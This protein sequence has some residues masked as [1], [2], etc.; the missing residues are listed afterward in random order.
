MQEEDEL[1]PKIGREFENLDEAWEFWTEYGKRIGFGVRKGTSTK[2]RADKSIIITYRFL[3]CKEGLR[4]KNEK[5]A[6]ASTHRPETRTNCKA[7]MVVS[8][9]GQKF[10]ITVIDREHNH[11]LHT[12]DTVSLLPCQRNI[13]EA[14]AYEMDLAEESGLEP[15]DTF[16]L[17]STYAGGPENLGYTMTDVKTYLMCKRKRHMKFGEVGCLLEYFQKQIEE[18]PA[19]YHKYQLD[20]DQHITNVFWADAR[21]LI[22][23]AH[24]GE[25]VSLDTTYSTNQ[26]HRP[27]ALFSGFNH[28][29]SVVIFGAALLYDETIESFKWLLETFLDAHIQKK[30]QTVFTDQDQAMARAL[31]EV[32]PNT[33]HCLCSWHLLKN[34]VKHLGNLMKDGSHFLTDFKKCMF[35]YVDVEKFEEAW[36]Q[37]LSSYNVHENGWLKSTYDIKEKWAWCYVKETC[38]LGM[39]STQISESVNADVKRCTKPKLDI[40][41]FFKRFDKVVAKKRYKE[42]ELEYESRQKIPRMV[43]QSAPILRQLVQ[44]YTPTVFDMFQEQWDLQFSVELI[45]RDEKESLFVYIAHMIDQEGEWRVEFKPDTHEI[46]CT[47]Q[48]FESTGIFCCHALK[49]YESKD[50]RV[51]PD[52]YILKR[53]TKEARFG[54]VHDV[55]GNE[56]QVDPRLDITQRYRQL[57]LMMGRLAS[58]AA[59]TLEGFTCVQ[60]CVIELENHI[61]N[62]NENDTSKLVIESQNMPKGFKKRDGKSSKRRWKGWEEKNLKTRRRVVSKAQSN[63]IPSLEA[64]DLMENYSQDFF[65]T[66]SATSILQPV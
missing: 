64:I 43:N 26:N 10:R 36:S 35:N 16:D 3:C 21:M 45:T 63:E 49:V 58:K 27:L 53:W 17:M 13:S 9:V 6:Y 12:K 50:V 47:C 34:G 51:M 59:K 20:P 39:R 55:R 14:Q 32:L 25:V 40:K 41:R 8:R 61:P 62:G 48:K 66:L 24:F 65:P 5:R 23:Y 52:Q 44:V 15:R 54:V 4:R 30:P 1:E 42:V 57:M 7:R 29:R 2:S 18:N 11:P 56:I 19:F 37:L 28:H 22:D 33:K 46:F 60:R 38:T 31:C